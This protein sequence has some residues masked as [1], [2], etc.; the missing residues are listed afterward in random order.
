M[1]EQWTVK[2]GDACLPYARRSHNNKKNLGCSPSVSKSRSLNA[3]QQTKNLSQ[4]KWLKCPW[5]MWASSRLDSE[6]KLVTLELGVLV[7]LGLPYWCWLYTSVM[8]SFGPGWQRMSLGDPFS[9]K[10]CK[11]SMNDVFIPMT[12]LETFPLATE[13]G[14]RIGVYS[15]QLLAGVR[16]NSC[17]DHRTPVG[18]RVDLPCAQ[19]GF[20]G[21]R[22]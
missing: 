6:L 19:K 14:S 12:V 4:P 3:N 17:W 18:R 9:S 13:W 21:G 5:I 2:G 7:L 22:Q 10:M 16:L 20:D 11:I 1:H 15:D 8:H